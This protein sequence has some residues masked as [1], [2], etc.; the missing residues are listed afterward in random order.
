MSSLT[1]RGPLWIS[2][3]WKAARLKKGFPDE[4]C[5]ESGQLSDILYSVNEATLDAGL[6]MKRM[7]RKS[8]ESVYHVTHLTPLFTSPLAAATTLSLVS[9]FKVPLSSSFPYNLQAEWWGSPFLSGKFSNGG[10]PFALS[11]PEYA[12]VL[13]LFAIACHSFESRGWMK[14]LVRLDVRIKLRVSTSTK[15][16]LC[17]VE[18]SGFRMYRFMLCHPATWR[19]Q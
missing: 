4:L 7:E 17:R 12:I 2:S 10:I 15:V 11:L 1:I 6:D 14:N 13:E 5:A 9:R 18:V 19:R 8:R 3:W 16:V